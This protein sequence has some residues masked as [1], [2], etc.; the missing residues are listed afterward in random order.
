VHHLLDRP[1]DHP[2]RTALGASTLSFYS[3][4][5]FAAS[6][7]LVAKWLKVPVAYV[8]N[9]FRAAVIVVPVVVFLLTHRLLRALARSKAPRFSEMPR[10]ALR[11]GFRPAEPSA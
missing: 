6:N 7:D 11:K 5:F 1:R 10:Q 4:L 3:V 2:F 8:T 9:A